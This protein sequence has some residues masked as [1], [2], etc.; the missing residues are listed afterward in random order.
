MGCTSS[1]SRLLLLLHLLREL[2]TV[3]SQIQCSQPSPG[4]VVR[5]HGQP[6]NHS[7]TWRLE[8]VC[9]SFK[10]CLGYTSNG[11]YAFLVQLCPLEIQQGDRVFIHRPPEN[12]LYPMRPALVSEQQWSS[13]Q[14]LENIPSNQTLFSS[15][16]SSITEIPQ[17][18][19]QPGNVYIAEIP[20]GFFS[21]NCL[22]G[23][24][25]NITV[26]TSNCRNSDANGTLCSGHGVCSS[27]LMSESFICRCDSGYLGN[28]CG[29]YDGCVSDP[30]VNGGT[31]IDVIQG[32]GGHNFTC[33]CPPPL[34]GEFV[35]LQLS[36]Q[37]SGLALKTDANS[38][39]YLQNILCFSLLPRDNVHGFV[40]IISEKSRSH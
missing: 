23:L 10:E 15:N 38:T 21:N 34:L 22:F 37:I 27:Q 4:E 6:A 40:M 17:E 24:R 9:S 35:Q 1:R 28:F 39:L 19:L 13:C 11:D 30:C 5:W 33:Q 31:C 16:S 25:L 29:E 36:N 14:M 32:L 18:L 7:R 20:N 12:I 8:L 2:C 26:K 3:L